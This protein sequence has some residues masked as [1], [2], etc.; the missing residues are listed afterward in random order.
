MEME[1]KANIIIDDY[2]LSYGDKE[3]L[4]KALI[5]F[6]EDKWVAN[7]TGLMGYYRSTADSI[8]KRLRGNV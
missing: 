8:L 1:I 6:L 5:L 7:G 3:V 4:E 2:E